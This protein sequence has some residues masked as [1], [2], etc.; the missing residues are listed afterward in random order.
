E[1][2][3]VQIGLFHVHAHVLGLVLVVEEEQD[4]HAEQLQKSEGEQLKPVQ[5]GQEDLENDAGHH[6]PECVH[7]AQS[8]APEPEPVENLKE[9]G[10]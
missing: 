9:A 3:E 7:H 1:G 10:P 4:D 8:V 2:V 5:D 6:H